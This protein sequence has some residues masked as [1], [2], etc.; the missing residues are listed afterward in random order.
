MR[1]H[2]LAT[3]GQF[4]PEILPSLD[5]SVTSGCLRWPPIKL[6]QKSGSNNRCVMFA[7]AR[8]L[9]EGGQRVMGSLPW[10]HLGLLSSGGF[11][12]FLGVVH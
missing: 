6:P 8:N 10:C 9:G 4:G 7:V 2:P 11:M 12:D 5:S 1:D 3:W